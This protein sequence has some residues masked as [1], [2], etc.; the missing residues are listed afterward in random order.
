VGA[1][2]AGSRAWRQVFH[3]QQATKP[4]HS[5][6]YVLAAEMVDTLRVMESL[7]RLLNK[8]VAGYAKDR[9]VYDDSGVVDPRNRLAGASRVLTALSADLVAAERNA[10]EFF[11]AIGHIGV[12]VDPER[13]GRSWT[14]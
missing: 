1:A 2:E 12:Q 3:T 11:N 7:A 10:N 6:F 4:D 8:Q 14:R 13:G 9:P 5:D